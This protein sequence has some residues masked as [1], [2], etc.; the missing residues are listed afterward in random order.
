MNL[1][2]LRFVLPLSF[3][4]SFP[5][6]LPRDLLPAVAG[7]LAAGI[8][9][10]AFPALAASGSPDW[11]APASGGIDSLTESLM[12][13][14]APLLGLVIVGFGAWSC[15]TGM[16]DWKRFWMFLLGGLLIGV[17]QNFGTWFNALF[18]S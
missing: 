4:G 2:L 7:V 14:G 13:L 18:T 15:M 6:K 16:F 11:I 17:G 8:A 1:R 5:M 10:H 9:F 3:K 12:T